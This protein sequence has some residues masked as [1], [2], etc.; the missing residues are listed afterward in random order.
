MYAAK[1]AA[2][3]GCLIL[4]CS[5][6][7]DFMLACGSLR[8]RCCHTHTSYSRG[9]GGVSSLQARFVEGGW[10]G[11]HAVRTAVGPNI[12]IYIYRKRLDLHEIQYDNLQKNAIGV[13]SAYYLRKVGSAAAGRCWHRCYSCFSYS[14][15]G[16]TYTR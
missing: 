6:G 10:G 4:F 14:G 2:V 15:G 12:Y 7:G 13:H 9:G 11:V 5:R 16:G 3:K 1:A 8:F